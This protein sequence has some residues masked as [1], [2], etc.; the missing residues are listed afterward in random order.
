MAERQPH[1]SESSSTNDE[2]EVFSAS[3][4]GA[5]SAGEGATRTLP[6]ASAHLEGSRGA[7]PAFPRVNRP[8]SPA[9]AKTASRR[10]RP[11]LFRRISAAAGCVLLSAV[12]AFLAI[13]TVKGQAIDTLSME[14]AMRWA[15]PLGSLGRTVTHII[16]VPAM[17]IIG[18]VV[19]VIAWLRRRPTLAGRALGMVIAANTTTQVAKLL[20]E[21]PDYHMSAATVN[22][23]PSG[24]TTVAMSLALAL[25]MIA[26]EWFRGPA[27]WVGYLWTS[28]VGISVMVFGWHRPSDVLVAMAVCG[29][30]AL[31]LCPLEDR[32]RHGVPVQKAMV[33]IALASAIVAALGLVYS[34][35]ALTP[36]DLAQMGSGGI[37]YAEFLD[38]LPR[39]AHVLAGIS[40]FAV[41]A[42]GG[43]VI[44]EVD[45]LSGE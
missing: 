30:W 27:A 10:Y 19:V 3:S 33:V 11:R 43:L 31:I 17:V 44:H 23:L 7:R 37:T 20:I 18:V 39:R 1:P 32:P 9:P 2:T 12:I 25:V 15:D 28:L 40:S 42:V 35:W 21:R 5:P 22:S 38:A 16:S 36:N 14:A 8:A 26:P 41:I 45:R 24:H 34:L 29:F 4:P 6:E 13:F